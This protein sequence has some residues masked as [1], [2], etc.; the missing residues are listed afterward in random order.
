MKSKKLNLSEILKVGLSPKDGVHLGL[1]RLK[2]LRSNGSY[3]V[4]CPI[5]TVT[6]RASCTPFTLSISD[7]YITAAGIY[8]TSTGTPI[9][10]Y[11]FVGTPKIVNLIEVVWIQD[12]VRT[13]IVDRSGPSLVNPSGNIIPVCNSIVHMNGQILCGGF[14]D[15]FNSLSEAFVGWSEIAL[16]RF[17]L[18]KDN[19]AG[20]YNPNIGK[21]YNI[22]AM[23]DSAIVFGSRGA[24]QMYYAGHIFGFRD[25][26]IELLKDKNLCASSTNIVV[27][28]GKTG[29][30]Y[31][32]DKNGES[33]LLGFKWIG[34]Q[35][36]SVS[37][38]NGRNTFVF[39]T[40][41]TSYLLDSKGMFSYGYKVWGEFTDS[42]CVDSS[43][44]QAT[45]ELETFAFDFDRPGVKNL[46]EV[47]VQ[48]NLKYPTA[49]T[50]AIKGMLDTSTQGP[51]PLNQV[52]ASKYPI[53]DVEFRL[54]YASAASPVITD[55]LV[56]VQ[57]LDRRFGAGYTPYNGGR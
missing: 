23:Q 18:S 2:N 21:V 13:Y 46:Q 56:E 1:A 19:T 16:D 40:A 8:K 45:F 50:V 12:S 57:D 7:Y 44:E 36:V 15:N 14:L 22:C 38:L 5:E 35:T 52:S 31:K 48:D 26:D 54:S 28:I 11:T 17:T 30:I 25:L 9:V 27:Y 29:D 42:L 53:S 32:V 20:F 10:V 4:G 55:I 41:S 39:T 34:S 37:Y 3:L 6:K 43:F 33:V 24:C 47:F 49:R 51:K